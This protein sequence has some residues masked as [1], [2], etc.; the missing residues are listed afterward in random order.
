MAGIYTHIPF[1]YSKCIYCGF[2][3]STKGSLINKYL[4][5]LKEECKRKKKIWDSIAKQEESHTLYIGG[6]TPS[7]L[8]LE[9]LSQVIEIITSTF[10]LHISENHINTEQV[11]AKPNNIG[12]FTIEVNPDDIT[13]QYALGLKKMG[14]NRVSMG[15]QSFI[16]KHLEWMHRRHSAQQAIEAFNILQNA[17]FN[18]ISLDLIFGFKQLSFKQLEFNIDQL[19]SL[20]PTHISTYQLSLDEGTPLKKMFEQGIDTVEEE[21]ICAQQYSYI[22]KKLSDNGYNQYEISN[23]SIEGYKSTHN[24]NYWN[25]TPYIGLGPGAHSFYDNKREWNI[26]NIDLYCQKNFNQI[27]QGETLSK[28]DIFNEIVMLSLRTTYGLNLN[29]LDPE[30]IS[31]KM[32]SF[33]KEIS[34]GNLIGERDSNGKIVQIKIPPEKLFVSDGI[35]ENLIF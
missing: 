23:F 12:E 3:S 32:N 22:Q 6:G 24:S 17:G 11:G 10:E 4:S 31:H 15:V 26:P 18:N 7:F 20:K 14:V 27:Y 16:D 19:L 9:D 1:C 33:E 28:E 25:R 5:A 29:I 35:I 34:C 2:Y 30:M 8:S 13:K 21:D